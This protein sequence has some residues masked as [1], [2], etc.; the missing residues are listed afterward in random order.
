MNE[1]TLP[2]KLSGKS[3][4]HQTAPGGTSIVWPTVNSLSEIGA[5]MTWPQGGALV[6]WNSRYP[7]SLNSGR[8]LVANETSTSAQSSVGSRLSIGCSLKIACL[9]AADDR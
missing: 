8:Y 5:L 2:M 9:G 6:S 4:S 3:I 1:I 7:F